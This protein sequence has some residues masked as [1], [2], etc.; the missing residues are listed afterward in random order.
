MPHDKGKANHSLEIM[1]EFD[2]VDDVFVIITHDETS[3]DPDIGLEFFPH[4][5]LES[6]KAKNYANR[7]RRAFPEDFRRAP[8]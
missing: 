5:D 1:R 3:L 4:G 7:S 2:A 6:W 8:E